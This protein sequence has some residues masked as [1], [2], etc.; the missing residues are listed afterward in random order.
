MDN[1]KQDL[2]ENYTLQELQSL[3]KY[4][5]LSTK[6]SLNELIKAIVGFNMGRQKASMLPHAIPIHEA[7]IR[8][9]SFEDAVNLCKTD[10]NFA[11]ACRQPLIWK[12]W[13]EAHPDE[14]DEALMKA[15]KNKRLVIVQGLLAGGAD[16]KSK[17]NVFS[18]LAVL[19]NAR[20]LLGNKYPLRWSYPSYKTVYIN[21]AKLNDHPSPSK[22][23]DIYFSTKKNSTLVFDGN[24]WSPVI[25]NPL[26]SLNPVPSPVDYD[27]ADKEEFK[28]Y[29]HGV[30]YA[31][32]YG[33]PDRLGQPPNDQLLNVKQEVIIKNPNAYGA[34]PIGYG[35][36][37]ERKM[38]KKLAAEQALTYL[39]NRG[40][41]IFL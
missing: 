4:Y 32:V 41:R 13:A 15:G 39:K 33:F 29:M 2:I 3:A 6:Q 14:R 12:T 26:S 10:K 27:P 23:G 28:K 40:Y 1:V 19:Y 7:L 17:E 36:H 21:V 34:V 9:M 5:Q 35:V 24:V 16:L 31:E 25:N 37:V 20:E 8:G 18:R 22:K 11:E 30:W 38:A